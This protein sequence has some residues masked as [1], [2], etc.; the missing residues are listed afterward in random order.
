MPY[1]RLA[2]SLSVAT[3]GLL[4]AAPSASAD[5]GWSVEPATGGAGGR[6]YVYAEGE[7]GTV[8]QD[9]VSVLNPGSEPLT[10]RLSGADADDTADG[11]FTVRTRPV[12]TGAWIAFARTTGGRRAAV[13]AVSVTVPAR[14]RADV[15]FS[16][17]V[18]GGAVPGDHPGAIVA[19]AGAVRPPYASNS[20]SGDSRCPR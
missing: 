1:A 19:S 9:A 8:L 13:H 18:P 7:P 15:P 16:L 6:P 14:T 3:L 10:V 20:A 5:G 17:T 4:G 2:L 11:G 12:D